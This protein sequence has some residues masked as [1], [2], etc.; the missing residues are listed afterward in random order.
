MAKEVMLS[1]GPGGGGGHGDFSAPPP[2]GGL[3]NFKG[4]MLCNRPTEISMDKA[5]S[6]DGPAPFKSTVSA[7]HND[8]LGLNPATVRAHTDA[9]A[10]L[11]G[12]SAA[13]RKHVKWLKEL[14]KQ[15]TDE[16]GKMVAEE[17]EAEVKKE[18]MKKFC[19]KQREAVNTLLNSDQEVKKEHLEE[20][21]HKAGAST[22]TKDGKRVKPL[23]AMTEQEKEVFQEKE[24]DDLLS[25]AEDLDFDKY[26]GDL[27]FR[28]NLEVLRDRAGKLSKEQES[29]KDAIVSEF[30]ADE[31]STAAGSP[32]IDGER[33]INLDGLEGSSLGVGEGVDGLGGKRSKHAEKR[34]DVDGKPDWDSSTCVGD[35]Q[36]FGE[37]RDMASRIL[38]MNPGVRG[39]HS[40]KSVQ[41]ILEKQKEKAQAKELVDLVEHLKKDVS[42]P[43]PVI[44]TSSDTQGKAKKKVDP[45]MLP[46]LYRSP[47]I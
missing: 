42:A 23:W 43:D 4:V 47:A 20:A 6:G 25:F 39:I 5:V 17:Q 41:K 11:R 44:V 33:S 1:D 27:E 40:E 18:K 31:E 13:L 38:E 24:A 14:Q 2:P 36:S 28:E 12:P 34:Y 16:R 8:Q 9:H 37:D 35:E 3:G 15:M 21:L 22:K 26:I 46:Y 45:S 32:R 19:E 10:K 29:F 7:T 30:N